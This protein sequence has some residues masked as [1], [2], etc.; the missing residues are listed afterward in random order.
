MPGE[1]P[2]PTTGPLTVRTINF[3]TT[4]DEYPH[5]MAKIAKEIAD[6]R[7]TTDNEPV[8]ELIGLEE[9]REN[10]TNCQGGGLWTSTVN[11]SKC[12]AALQ[13]DLGQGT[14]GSFY[15]GVSYPAWFDP[16]LG[17]GAVW[18]KG[19]SVL[20]RNRWNIGPGIEG[21]TNY[22]RY[23]LEVELLH[24]RSAGHLRFYVTHLYPGHTAERRRIRKDQALEL[25]NKVLSRASQHDLPPILVGDFNFDSFDE[26]AAILIGNHFWRAPLLVKAACGPQPD[27]SYDIVYIGKK[28]S[29]PYSRGTYRLGRLRKVD[30][31]PTLSDHN[32]L[33]QV[34]WVEAK[35]EREPW[36]DPSIACP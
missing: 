35:Q 16:D 3:E 17:G 23:L 27:S 15:D 4:A 25:I 34:M 20:Q 5:R 28:A 26:D 13:K 12:F 21:T 32:S 11:G 6:D 1:K 24:E 7:Q 10:M 30:L 33:G 9:A 31:S 14:F 8:P 36:A 18:S 29:F 19:F 2:G 22:D